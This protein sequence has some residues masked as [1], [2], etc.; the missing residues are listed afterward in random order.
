MSSGNHNVWASLP[1]IS[2][3]VLLVISQAEH[4]AGVFCVQISLEDEKSEEG[5]LL[6]ELRIRASDWSVTGRHEIDRTGHA[7]LG[8]RL[9]CFC[10]TST[11]CRSSLTPCPSSFCP[12]LGHR[13]SNNAEISRHV[14]WGL[15]VCLVGR[16]ALSQ[17]KILLFLSTCHTTP[18]TAVSSP[19]NGLTFN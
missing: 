17:E 4:R 6:N 5:D 16:P 12:S 11:S 7:A 13:S 3:C 19:W 9:W 18:L 1:E 14:C 15:R 10:C 2:H 8:S